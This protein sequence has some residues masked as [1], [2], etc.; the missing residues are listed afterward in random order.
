MQQ[1]PTAMC[2]PRNLRD[3]LHRAQLVIRVHYGYQ[4][5]IR[6]QRAPHVLRI[7]RSARAHGYA[8]HRYSLALQLRHRSQ[9]RRMLDRRGNYMAATGRPHRSQHSQ[10]ICFRSAA[11]EYQLFRVTANQGRCFPPC[12]F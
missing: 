7:H 4:R 9:H 3:R 1:R 5:R 8:R 12:R 10:I 6:P 2:D 11:C